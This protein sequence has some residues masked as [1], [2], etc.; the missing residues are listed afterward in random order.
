MSAPSRHSNL[1]VAFGLA[2]LVVG[3]VGVSY[4]AVPLYRWICQVTGFGGTTMRAEKAP[5]SIGERVMTVRFNADVA[6]TDLPWRFRP[7]EKQVTL[8][9][10]EERLAFYRASNLGKTASIGTATFNVTPHKAAPYFNKLACF[11]FSEQE[12]AAGETMEMPVSFFIDPAIVNDPKLRDVDTITLSY[13][14]FRA[15]N[16]VPKGGLPRTSAVAN[17]AAAPIN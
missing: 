3:M 5:D 12:L 17:P 8:H 11:C 1:R 2:S 4:A 15:Q 13:T 14:F 9:V 7:L 10:G 6:G 16:A